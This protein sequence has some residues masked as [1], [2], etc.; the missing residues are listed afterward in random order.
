MTSSKHDY[1]NYDQ[2]A[3]NFDMTYKTMQ[4]VFVQNLKFL[5]QRG[6]S[7]WR[8]KLKKFL[9]IMLYGKMG[10]W[11]FFCPPTGLLQYKRMEIFKLRTAITLAFID[12]ST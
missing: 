6:Q 12:M 4:H 2:F 7:Y 9:I 10:R 11:A 8:R 1:A 3:T 5:D